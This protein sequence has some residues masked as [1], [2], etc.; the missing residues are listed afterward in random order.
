MS[1]TNTSAPPAPHAD[2]AQLT[3]HDVGALEG[4][5]SA[6]RTRRGRWMMVWVVF[7]CALP[8]IASYFTFYVIQ[9]RGQGYGSLVQPPRALPEDLDLRD[10]QG[11]PVAAKSLHQQWLLVVVDGGSCVGECEKH[12]YLQQQLRTMLGKEMDKLDKVWLVNDDAPL[13][14]ELQ[15]KLAEGPGLAGAARQAGGAGALVGTGGGAAAERAPVFG[16]P[17]RGVDVALA[18]HPGPVAGQEGPEPPAQGERRLGSTGPMSNVDL[19]PLLQLLLLGLA[20]GTL[21]LAY[22]L[23][24]G[25]GQA[26][27]QRLRALLLVTLFLTFDL[28]VFG[29]FTRLSDSGLGCPDWPGCFGEVSPM[30]ARSEIAEQQALRPQGPVTHGKAWV[31]M[32][33]R[34]WASAVGFLILV[35]CFLA[36]RWRTRLPVRAPAW[37]AFTLLWVLLQ[38]AFGALTVT[39]KL[40]PAIV[41]LHL[42]FGLGLLVL[43]MRQTQTLGAAPPLALPALRPWAWASAGMLLLQIALGGW[44]STNYAVLICPDFPTCQGQWWPSMD[45]AQGF[46]LWRELGQTRSGEWLGLPALTAIHIAHRLG[47]AGADGLVAGLGGQTVAVGAHVRPYAAGFAGPATADGH[48]KCGAGLAP[49]GRLAA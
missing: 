44:V 36:W 18:G 46:T 29:A 17:A 27:S 30:G 5:T 10:L 28:V 9:P 21:P 12:L 38:G 23:L 7:L 2:P 14:S 31:E 47:S 15:A 1:G 8:V 43:L 42:L 45:F 25:R 22:W 20:L 49:A 24:R 26:A 48:L 11:R 34:Y 39:M 37:A 32:V 33:H 16:G 13:S 40:F 4:L 3:V 19:S 35:Q 41:T 6:E